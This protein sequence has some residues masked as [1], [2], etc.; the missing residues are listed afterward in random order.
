MS[1]PLII[2]LCTAQRGILG[3][4]PPSDLD[5]N[6]DTPSCIGNAVDLLGLGGVFPGQERKCQGKRA[7]SKKMAKYLVVMFGHYEGRTRDLGVISTTL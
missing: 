7:K 1:T 4:P 2:T 5:W 3:A 6:M